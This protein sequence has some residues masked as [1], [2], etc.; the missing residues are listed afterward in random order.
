VPAP[1]GTAATRASF[2]TSYDAAL[3]FPN[4]LY[5]L[6]APRMS[7]LSAR[8]R[9]IT[10]HE[11]RLSHVPTITPVASASASAS[12]RALPPPVPKKKRGRRVGTWGTF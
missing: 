11:P 3:A 7:A 9:A 6:S 12:A 8:L 1:S 10:V 5:A 4:E 2:E